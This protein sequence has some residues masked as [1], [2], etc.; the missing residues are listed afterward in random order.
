MELLFNAQKDSLLA[1]ATTFTKNIED[2]KDVVQEVFLECLEKKVAD[3]IT[4]AYIFKAVKNRA[5]NRL[6]SRKRL[7]GFIE[8]C[9]EQ[10]SQLFPITLGTHIG[11]MEELNK[12]PTKQKEAII[13][14][15]NGELKISEIAEVLDIPEGT[16][17][18]RINSGLT[19]LRKNLRG[20]V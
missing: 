18:S 15:I 20:D 2:S 10:F 5:L 3:K 4:K 9:K 13:L 14:R 19:R 17:K 11:V 6:R 1:F 7:I 12:L 16:V 8:I